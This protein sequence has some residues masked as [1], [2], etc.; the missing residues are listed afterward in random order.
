MPKNTSDEERMVGSVAEI[1]KPRI[2]S[3]QK[4][5]LEALLRDQTEAQSVEVYNIDGGSKKAGTSSG[6][7]MFSANMDGIE[8]DLVLRFAPYQNDLRLFADYDIEGQYNIHRQLHSAG[9]RVPNVICFETTKKHLPQPGYI[10]E[11]VDGEVS[12]AN[13]Y[14]SGFFFESSDADRSAMQ[15]EILIALGEIHSVDWQALG[16]EKH[17]T[18]AEGRTL[19]EKHLNWYWKTVE[20]ARYPNRDRLAGFKKWLI[21]NQPGYHADD[22]T[23]VHGDT[24]IANYMFKGTKLVAVI[25]WE[26]SGI[27]HPSFDIGA[28][29]TYN[30][31][32]RIASPAEVQKTIPTTAALITRYEFLIG[33]RLQDFEYFLK[34]AA[35]SGLVTIGSMMRAMPDEY[36]AANARL[37]EPLWAIADQ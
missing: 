5:Q 27:I 17:A 37:A 20:W 33:R 23:L 36:K 4:D 28:Q 11:R 22:Y 35:F 6:I 21:D 10:M 2:D 15:D 12:D 18:R 24:N 9:L 13:A 34:L 14:A 3:V 8:S 7:V 19:I 25:D 30:E 16:L 1:M 32:C 26:M 31:Y 29:C